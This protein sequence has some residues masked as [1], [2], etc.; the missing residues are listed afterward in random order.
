[1][2]S[3]INQE[4][5][6]M[7]PNHINPVQWSQAIGYARQSCARIYRDGGTPRDA[8]RA[9]GLSAREAARS[10]WDRAVETIA[11]SLCVPAR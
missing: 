3:D 2:R 6:A 1:M 4:A 9:F 5:N 11:I 7:T 10:D 8:M